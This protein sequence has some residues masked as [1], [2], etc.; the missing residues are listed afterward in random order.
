[1]SKKRLLLVISVALTVMVMA[2]PGFGQ[3]VNGKITG[4]VTDS[5]G[6]VIPNI[7]LELVNNDTGA[8]WPTKS[9][10]SGAYV[11]DNLGTGMYTLTAHGSGFAD[12]TISQ[13]RVS[14]AQVGR[15]DVVLKLGNVSERLMYRLW[16]RWWRPTGHR[17]RWW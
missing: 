2:M 11:F 15:I 4:N 16:R 3:V 10:E 1:M 13:I 5:T 9:N 7:D 8:R 6:A 17:F 12:Y 14:V